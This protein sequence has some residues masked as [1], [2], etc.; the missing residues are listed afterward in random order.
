[1]GAKVFISCSGELSKDIGEAIRDW[2]PKVLQSVK[3][4]FTPDDIEKGA[5]WSDE[6]ANE[7][8]S[9]QLG[10]ICLTLENQNSPWILFEA[11]ALSKNIE[12]SKVYPILFNFDTIDLSGP[13]ASFQA[14]KF[15]K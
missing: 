4:Y 15:N 12:E 1:M 13:L 2:L 6:I 5:R 10:I 11:G 7:L 9:S 8:S 3:P 14:T